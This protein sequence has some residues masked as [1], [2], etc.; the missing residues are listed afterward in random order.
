MIMLSVKRLIHSFRD[1]WHGL[2]HVWK[3][4]QNFQIQVFIAFLVMLAI[5]YFPLRRYE[6]IVLILLIVSVLAMELMNTA[7]EY[8]A[9]LF[10]P[11]IHPYIG[12]IK[13]IM[14]GAVLIT[15]VGALTI[16]I[17]ILGPYFV[18]LIK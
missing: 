10:K 6:T 7:L 16:G 11:R 14:A 13:D 9:D 5:W 1:A 4:E 3:H 12:L 17:I 2:V 8:F 15:S 18:S